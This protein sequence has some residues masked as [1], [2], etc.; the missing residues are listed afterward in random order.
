MGISLTHFIL[1]FHFKVGGVVSCDV[2]EYKFL[3]V[4]R[5]VDGWPISAKLNYHVTPTEVFLCILFCEDGQGLTPKQDKFVCT[6]FNLHTV[7]LFQHVP[8]NDDDDEGDDD[9]DDDE[10]GWI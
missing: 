1:F 7:Y 9:D 2:V 8:L 6:V 3:T 4:R 10:Q 5:F